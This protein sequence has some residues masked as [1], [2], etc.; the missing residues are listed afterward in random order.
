MRNYRTLLV[1]FLAVAG[2]AT[3]G[4]TDSTA[5]TQ[6]TLTLPHDALTREGTSANSS[7]FHPAPGRFQSVYGAGL[8]GLPTGARLHGIRFRLDSSQTPFGPDTVAT[9]EIRLSTS[10]HPPGSLHATFANNRGADEVIART[11]PLLVAP[12]DYGTGSAPNAFGPPIEFTTPFVY[13]GG[14]LLLEIGFGGLSHP[15]L[16]DND[17]PTTVDAQSGYG[18]NGGFDAPDA[19]VGF[20]QDLI[21]VQFLYD[22]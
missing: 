13:Q 11:G 1:L 4:G 3:C 10:A 22:D 12:S 20:F 9:L 15:R 17:Y 16:I 5:P 7:V 6:H 14:P 19:D 21:V 2:L 8:L 18:T